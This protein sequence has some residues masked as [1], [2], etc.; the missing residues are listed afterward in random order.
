MKVFAARRRDS[1]DIQF[2][3]KHLGLSSVDQV[4]ALCAD[5][6]PDEVVP[7]RARLVVEDAVGE[8]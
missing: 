4:L 6:F 8:L 5:A 3:I 1:E 7:E 2:L